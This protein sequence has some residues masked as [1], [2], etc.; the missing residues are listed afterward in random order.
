MADLIQIG[1]NAATVVC[2]LGPRIRSFFDRIYNSKPSVHGLLLDVFREADA[3]I[4]LCENKTIR[5]HGLTTLLGV[6]TTS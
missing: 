2:P 1:A 5:P 4:N 6:H 3:L